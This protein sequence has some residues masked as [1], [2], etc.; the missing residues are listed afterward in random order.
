ML[1]VMLFAIRN[2]APQTPGATVFAIVYLSG[3]I[4]LTTGAAIA[5]NGARGGLI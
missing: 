5:F 4:L 1:N 2:P 3:A